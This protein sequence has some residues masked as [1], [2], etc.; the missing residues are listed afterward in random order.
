[1]SPMK[2]I[3]YKEVRSTVTLRRDSNI[4]GKRRAAV[5]LRL[6]VCINVRD[7]TDSTIKDYYKV[8]VIL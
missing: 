6:E 7:M 8:R 4:E 3:L 5:A 2:Q 1:L